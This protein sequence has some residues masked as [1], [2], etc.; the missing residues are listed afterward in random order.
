MKFGRLNISI[1]DLML[2]FVPLAIVMKFMDIDPVWIFTISCL[3]IVPLAG[4]MGKATEH[5]AG[6]YGPGIGGAAQ[7]QLRQRRGTH[8]CD[9]GPSRRIHRRG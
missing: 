3:A 4:W 1:L 7:C 9:H 8:H 5:L 6:H 2:V